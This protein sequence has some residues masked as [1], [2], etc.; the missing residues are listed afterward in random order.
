[1]PKAQK[2][3]ALAPNDLKYLKLLSLPYV[4]I[5]GKLITINEDKSGN[6]SFSASGG[7]YC[8]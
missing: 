5:C 8:R 6:P 3:I 2:I 4:L 7:I 1:M